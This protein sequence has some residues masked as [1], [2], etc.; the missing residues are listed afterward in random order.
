MFI[1]KPFKSTAEQIEILKSRGLLFL[2]LLM[3]NYIY[4][5]TIIIML[6]IVTVDF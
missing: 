4:L 3:L 2:I 6:L 1:A 5:K